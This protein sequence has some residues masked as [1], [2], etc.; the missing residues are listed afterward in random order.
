MAITAN[1]PPPDG[2]TGVTMKVSFNVDQADDDFE[3]VISHNVTISAAGTGALP[4]TN[5]FT[6][7]GAD[8]TEDRSEKMRVRL[9]NGANRQDTGQ[10]TFNILYDDPIPIMVALPDDDP[11]TY[12]VD[13]PGTKPSDLDPRGSVNFAKRFQIGFTSP[14]NIPT[15]NMGNTRCP[16]LAGDSYLSFISSNTQ[17]VK[18]RSIPFSCNETKYVR[19]R[20]AGSFR[21]TAG[22][23]LTHATQG[24]TRPIAHTGDASF[25]DT[26]QASNSLFPSK[27][28]AGFSASRSA[29]DEGS[30][31][32][33]TANGY[34]TATAMTRPPATRRA[35]GTGAPSN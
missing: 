26:V 33:I 4:V 32:A 3:V 16:K 10:V 21:I 6:R 7:T 14:E 19:V 27:L 17:V 35:T 8:F 5:P 34:I 22:T 18:N 15:S 1:P 31:L 25:S 30:Q 28:G 2:A 9:D 29:V 23:Q 13:G 12:A 20:S 11:A 24:W